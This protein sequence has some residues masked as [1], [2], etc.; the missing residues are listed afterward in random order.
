MSD[1]LRT[2]YVEIKNCS[3]CLLMDKEKSLR[4]I[5]AVDFNCDVFI[6]SQALAES[7]LRRSGVN[8]FSAMGT[9]GNTGGNLE[10]FLNRLDRTIYP[11][12]EIPISENVK[13]P[14]RQDGLL[15]VY[16]TEITQCYPG[17]SRKGDRVP[18]KEEISACVGKNFLIREINTIKPK[19][20][21]LMG[22]LSRDSFYTHVLKESFPKSLSEHIKDVTDIGIPTVKVGEHSL[23]VSPIQHASG[24]NP[25]FYKMLKNEKLI[26]LL[27]DIL[28]LR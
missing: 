18:S 2:L 12:V 17:K 24:A 13:I 7:Q 19:L 21:L 9:V 5:E 10:K 20:L 14:K 15:S 3:M 27:R 25:E 11:P 22:R 1:A 23:S 16:N 4:V 8:F 28:R 26:A 6:I